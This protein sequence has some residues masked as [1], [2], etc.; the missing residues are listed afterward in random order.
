MKDVP[1]YPLQGGSS[2]VSNCAFYSQSNGPLAISYAPRYYYDIPDKSY[3]AIMHD[4]DIGLYSYNRADTETP[5]RITMNYNVP[6]ADPKNYG[7]FDFT[8]SNVRVEEPIDGAL[9]WV[10]SMLDPYAAALGIGNFSAFGA[11][12]G[13]TIADIDASSSVYN[14]TFNTTATI[15]SMPIWGL[16]ASSRPTNITFKNIKINGEYIT[17]TNRD[18]FIDWVSGTAVTGGYTDPDDQGV[19][20][21]FVTGT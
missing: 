16:D 21:T 2:I 13:I 11:I 12:S 18:N 10:G 6:G 14:G 20:I 8:L 15:S 17:N 4:L 3:Q 5:I 1:G 9:F 7:L 19:N